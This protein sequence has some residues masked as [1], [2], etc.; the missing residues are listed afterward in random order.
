MN[1]FAQLRRSL[2]LGGCVLL[3]A[4]AVW[5][6]TATLQGE[7]KDA[8]GQPIKGAVIV[9]DRKDIKGHYQVKSD[10]K[11]HWLYTGLPLGMFDVS[12]QMD[13][14]EVD[15]VSNVKASIGDD[16]PPIN[17]DMK[18][19]QAQQQ[20]MAQAASSGQLTDDQQRG[21]SK[22]QKEQFEAAAKQRSEAMKKNK[23]LNDAFN[24]GQEAYKK[25]QVDTDKAQKVTDYQAAVDSFNKAAQLDAN[26]PA[27]WDSL[28][29]SYYGLGNAQTG[30]DKTKSYD[31]ALAAY[32]K[33]VA[34]KPDSAGAYNQIGNIY[35]AEKK[36]PEATEALQKAAQLDPQM[37]G[38]AYFNLGANLVNSGQA[39]KAAEFFKK[40]TD[41]DPNY[42]EAWYQL[43]SL[44]MSKGTVDSKTGQQAYPP[45]TAPALQKYLQLQPSGPHAQEATAMLT[46][47]GEKVQTNVSVPNAKKKK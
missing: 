28:G 22:E 29:A 46:A 6:Q 10:K 44:L 35:G 37:A 8:N 40:A 20:A 34:L 31:G 36:I 38:K 45:D 30:D 3:A 26:Q 27:V 32:Q 13:G 17:F 4:S 2:T 12:L 25:A 9:L 47:M 43:G 21:M 33:E 18:K 15:K 16:N 14:K 41:A 23:A 1:M 11:G 39:D 5:A 7:V 42:A 19:A 24:A